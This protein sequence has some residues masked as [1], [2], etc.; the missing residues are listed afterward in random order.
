MN[1]ES[2]FSEIYDEK[3]SNFKQFL[4]TNNSKKCGKVRYLDDYETKKT[5]H[6]TIEEID[7][8]EIF[9]GKVEEKDKEILYYSL[10]DIPDENIQ[11][12]LKMCHIDYITANHKPNSIF[13]IPDTKAMREIEKDIKEKLGDIPHDSPEGVMKI[14]TSKML[15]K[16]FILDIYGKVD[17]NASFDYRIPMAYP[18]EHDS[19]IVY[20]RTSRYGNKAFFIKLEK[21]KMK[22]SAS[23]DMKDAVEC[24][25]MQR[26]GKHP[27]YISFVF[28]GNLI[29]II[30]KEEVN[31]KVTLKKL[32][33]KSINE[34]NDIDDAMYHVVGNVI[35]KFGV[36]ECQK[37]YSANLLQ[38]AFAYISKFG[39]DVE[40]DEVI[41]CE[42]CGDV[43]AEM[44]KI[45][46]PS[47]RKSATA[48]NIKKIND[49]SD[50]YYDGIISK[51]F[52]QNDKHEYNDVNYFKHLRSGYSQI[53]ADV[54]DNEFVDNEIA[55][56]VAYGIYDETN[57]IDLALNMLKSVKSSMRGVSNIS[58]V[59]LRSLIPQIATLKGITAQQF[60]P[61][62]NISNSQVNF[63]MKGG[64]D[65]DS[66]L[67]LEFGGFEPE[68]PEDVEK[69]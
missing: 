35:K 22:I 61:T 62:L 20:R 39:E 30:D 64:A 45:Y 15:Y 7:D 54:D 25:F 37:Y 24:K 68:T 36:T 34:H 56:D 41:D 16:A 27:K 59:H 48:T 53:C 43:H 63:D 51:V 44:L 60:F 52:N 23:S 65:E 1:S 14:K 3:I 49:Y 67:E 40:I 6:G 50:K 9:G 19:S 33:V 58:N 4:I 57:N 11:K 2:T 17:N 28:S 13:I 32:F 46:R 47:Q 12:Y 38:S 10:N 26:I 31:E 18:E 55:A 69:M 8:I 42:E 66:E 5:T 21:D 29:P